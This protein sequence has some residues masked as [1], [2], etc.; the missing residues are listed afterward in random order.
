M[1]SMKRR[2]FL[3]LGA[4]SILGSGLA[5]IP[6]YMSSSL[7]A[8]SQLPDYKALVCV[9]LHGGNDAFNLIVPS[10]ADSYSEYA[11]S[12]QN[13][14][15]AQNS[16]LPISPLSNDGHT[17]GMHPQAAAL[18]AL[19][20]DGKLAVMANVGNVL[21]PV[22]KDL[23]RNG[24]VSLPT[25][26]FSHNNQQHQWKAINTSATDNS[27]WGGRIA[28]LFA[29]QQTQP[30]LT[31]L[32][33]DGNTNWLRHPDFLGLSISPSGFDDYWYIKEGDGYENKRRTAHLETLYRSYAK[34][35]HKEIAETNTRT[36]EL[37]ESVGSVLA[38]TPELTT[39]FPADNGYQLSSQLKMVANM[40]AARDALGMQRQVFFVEMGG[41]DTHDDHNQ[42]QPNLFSMLS[43]SLSA[44]YDALVEVGANSDVTTFTASEFGRTLTSNGDGT[45]HGWGNHQIVMGDSVR[46]SN[47]YGT[48]PSLEIG[49]VDDHGN[50][51]RIIPSTS[52]EQ[53]ANSMLQ[54]YGLD[55]GQIQTVLPNHAVFDMN[56]INLMI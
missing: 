2:E 23:I 8:Q 34:Q 31:G 28:N 26:L 18:Q 50:R 32:S 20:N 33:L 16:L 22:T 27:G 40:I 43:N 1:S 51:G 48:M 35:F 39:V 6:G 29:S 54:W 24:S 7:F 45:D 49:G 12:R 4:A 47:I 46:G 52:V 21:E 44:F 30:L 41:F 36:L 11:N 55:A 14:A 53:Y 9:F 19:F 5:N 3:K 42:D 15:V 13:L 25:E 56:K 17:Y 37:V 10:D 38:N